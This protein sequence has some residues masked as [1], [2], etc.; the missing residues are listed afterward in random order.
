MA[1][2]SIAS[3]PTSRA[4]NSSASRSSDAAVTVTARRNLA[5]RPSRTSEAGISGDADAPAGP[6]SSPG[7]SVTTS[8]RPRASASRVSAAVVGLPRPFSRLAM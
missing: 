5:V 2:A 8:R 7:T 1:C 6:V 4:E 3:A